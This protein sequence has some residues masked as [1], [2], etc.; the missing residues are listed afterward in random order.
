MFEAIVWPLETIVI[1]MAG[2][3]FLLKRRFFKIILLFS[4]S[5]FF[6]KMLFRQNIKL[7]KNDKTLKMFSKFE[8]FYIFIDLRE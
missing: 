8:K 1:K 5:I 2:I 7:Q 6:Q 4:V 3:F